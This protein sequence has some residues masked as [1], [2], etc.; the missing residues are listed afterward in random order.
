LGGAI[1]F[2]LWLFLLKRFSILA[3]P[4]LFSQKEKNRVKEKKETKKR[5]KNG[6]ATK[7][8]VKRGSK[9]RCASWAS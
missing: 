7:Q 4:S 9:L 3:G 6:E 1:D 5:C 2:S 8:Q